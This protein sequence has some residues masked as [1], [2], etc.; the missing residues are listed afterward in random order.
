MAK[1]EIIYFRLAQ[2]ESAAEWERFL[3][4][5]T[6]CGLSSE[7]EMICVDG[8]SGLLA[9]LPTGF[10]GKPVQHWPRCAAPISSPSRP[11]CKP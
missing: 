5:L 10:P 6:H 11:I 9:T 8:G 1:K 2:S 4:D 7:I 3:G